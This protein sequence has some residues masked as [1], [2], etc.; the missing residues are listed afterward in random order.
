MYLDEDLALQCG[1]RRQP[2]RLVGFD[3]GQ[4]QLVPQDLCQ[5]PGH[6]LLLGNTAVVLDGED[7]RV[8]DRVTKGQGESEDMAL[9]HIVT[10]ILSLAYIG[11]AY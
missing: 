1:R 2:P 5:V 4:V 3:V 6:L 10:L 8:S 11:D 9:E 7:D